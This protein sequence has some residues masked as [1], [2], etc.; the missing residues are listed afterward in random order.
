MSSHELYTT[1]RHQCHYE[2]LN[3]KSTVDPLQCVHG[4]GL[5]FKHCGNTVFKGRPPVDSS[6]KLVCLCVKSSMCS[7]LP[8]A[9]VGLVT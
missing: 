4:S 7:K 1:N 6:I 9:H 5:E 8:S 3:R 2:T